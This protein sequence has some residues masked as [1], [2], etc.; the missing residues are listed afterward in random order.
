[1]VP[2]VE[3]EKAP[4][5]LDNGL[6][7]V[8]S[9]ETQKAPLHLDDPSPPSS[10][11]AAPSV[12]LDAASADAIIPLDTANAAVG[13][14][15]P[16]LD[17]LPKGQTLPVTAGSPQ[18]L[19]TAEEFLGAPPPPLSPTA[20]PLKSIPSRQERADALIDAITGEMSP[21]HGA[22]EVSPNITPTQRPPAPQVSNDGIMVFVPDAPIT[23]SSLDGDA[24]PSPHASEQNAPTQSV[25]D[26]SQPSE[27]LNAPLPL[28]RLVRPARRIA[29]GH[30]IAKKEMDSHDHTQILR[31]ALLIG[32]PTFIVIVGIVVTV[33][34]L[35]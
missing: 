4:L 24:S 8:P 7:D 16:S 23:E 28:E 9:V 20:P 26:T 21:D 13:V 3:T 14:A 32:I 34:L 11:R 10:P 30:G 6:T 22:P 15:L 12:P 27:T 35:H 18:A 31:L 19:G 25:A 2:S 5:H 33:V 29:A 17:E 1:D